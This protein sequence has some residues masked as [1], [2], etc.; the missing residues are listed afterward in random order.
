MLAVKLHKGK[1]PWLGK[2]SHLIPIV[3]WELDKIRIKSWLHILNEDVKKGWM[4]KTKARYRYP[5][6]YITLVKIPDEHPVCLFLS[7]LERQFL[8]MEI[9][10]TPLR[11]IPEERKKALMERDKEGPS[12]WQP[13]MILGAPLPESCIVW[14][15]DIRLLF[16]GDKRRKHNGE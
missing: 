5:I 6:R 11:D 3:S 9:K 13:E 1:K 4:P 2:G 8:G 15:K 16:E 12:H 14:T 10:F 7:W